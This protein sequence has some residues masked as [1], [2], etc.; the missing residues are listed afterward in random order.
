[1]RGLPRPVKAT[2]EYIFSCDFAG[3]RKAGGR[4][5]LLFRLRF[6]LGVGGR[7]ST[8]LDHRQSVRSQAHVGATAQLK[9]PLFYVV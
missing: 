4:R 1:M 7:V 2:G 6:L 3:K 9:S 8:A 5:V